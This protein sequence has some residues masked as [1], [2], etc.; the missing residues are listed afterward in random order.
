MLSDTER[1]DLINAP[2]SDQVSLR[3]AYRIGQIGAND[4]MVFAGDR[5]CE[6]SSTKKGLI[7]GAPIPKLGETRRSVFIDLGRYLGERY[8]GLEY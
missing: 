6:I 7:H 3:D 4:I 2:L 5:A 1:Q 8:D